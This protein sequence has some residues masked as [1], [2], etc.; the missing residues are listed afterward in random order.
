MLCF[1]R[2]VT[3]SLFPRFFSAL[4]AHRIFVFILVF[5]EQVQSDDRPPKDID[6]EGREMKEMKRN[7]KTLTQPFDDNLDAIYYEK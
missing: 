6:R 1:A 7:N 3:L 2:K 5:N 4:H